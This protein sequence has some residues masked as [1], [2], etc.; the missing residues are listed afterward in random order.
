MVM[1]GGVL[2]RHAGFEQ[3][4]GLVV[5]HRRQRRSSSGTYF[6]EKNTA[7][8]SL[9]SIC[10]D[11]G[12]NDDLGVIFERE[13]LLCTGTIHGVRKGVQMDR[14]AARCYAILVLCEMMAPPMTRRIPTS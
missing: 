9:C 12:A 7:Q 6:W 2:F 1:V 14:V 4:E 11:C 13:T 10:K 3:T 8:I 5:V